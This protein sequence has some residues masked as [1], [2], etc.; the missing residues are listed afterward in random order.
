[1]DRNDMVTRQYFGQRAFPSQDRPRGVAGK[2]RLI[3]ALV[4][5]VFALISYFGS[6]SYNPVT[7]ED[8]YVSI[9]AEQ[10]IALGLQAAPSMVQQFGGLLQD[11]Q[12]Q[13]LVDRVGKSVVRRSPAAQSGYPFEF[14]A[15]ADM[16][17]VNAF[18]LPGG[19]I[20]ITAA[21]LSKL[22]TE[23]QLAGVLSHEVGHVVGRHG[24]EHLAKEELTQGLT[25]SVLLATFDPDNPGSYNT[26]QMAQV[27]ASLI[28]N[29]YGR[30][31]E[32]ES[33]RFGVAYMS[34]AGY[35][36]GAMIRVQEIL[37]ELA[38]SGRPPEFLSTHPNPE[39]RIAVIK[40]AIDAK[41]PGGVPEG[42]TP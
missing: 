15:L 13:A 30:D 12:A 9:T 33:D 5:A 19:Q 21:L 20:F 36:P 40:E 6:K 41:F 28:N 23:G 3:V 22:E 1:M 26:A 11:E 24:A 17:T 18:A 39:N 35:N 8:Q 14:H 42:M 29:K 7:G 34:D 31:D 25:G 37:D 32:L 4:V 2:G 10:E 27:V 16:Q 38:G